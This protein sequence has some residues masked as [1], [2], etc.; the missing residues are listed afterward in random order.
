VIGSRLGTNESHE[1]PR[2]GQRVGRGPTL[3]SGGEQEPAAPPAAAPS[4]A[5]AQYQRI[6]NAAKRH[7][8]IDLDDLAGPNRGYLAG[9]LAGLGG[10]AS[11][12]RNFARD[13][14]RLSLPSAVEVTAH[15]HVRFET[16]QGGSYHCEE[17]VVG[18]HRS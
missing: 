17:A 5:S 14:L 13:L 3:G 1:R 18:C 8:Q 2:Y 4:S 15:P 6:A 16:V 12:E 7:L 11:I 9:A 10:G